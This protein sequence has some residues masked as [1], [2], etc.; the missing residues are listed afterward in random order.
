M[1]LWQ[2]ISSHLA[3]ERDAH[4]LHDSVVFDR[5]VEG[6]LHS[7]VISCSHHQLSVLCDQLSVGNPHDTEL[8][9]LNDPLL[10]G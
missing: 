1:Y 9:L 7:L 3:V 4:S 10:K 6:R 5:C 8:N 2:W